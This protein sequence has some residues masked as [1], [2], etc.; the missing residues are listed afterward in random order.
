M[1]SPT[2]IAP[3]Q[4]NFNQGYASNIIR[5]RGG[6]EV[7]NTYPVAAGYTAWMMDEE[8]QMF[9]IKT[10]DA[11]GIPSP[12]RE[13]KFEEVTPSEQ[14]GVDFSKFVTKDDLNEFADS[15]ASNIF[16]KLQA[17]QEPVK[18]QN[19]YRPNRR[20]NNGQHV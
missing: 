20:N 3:Q 4:N 10:N 5:I 8:N 1:V 15:L 9:F 11:S 6:R 19:N 2:Q 7:A 12:L 17:N 16:E 14:N 18:H 13:F